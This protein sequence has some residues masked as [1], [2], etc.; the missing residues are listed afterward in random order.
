MSVIDIEN[1]EI[2]PCVLTGK[3]NY[4]EYSWG[5][6]HLNLVSPISVAKCKDTGMLYL[7]PRPNKK[8]REAMLAGTLPDAL[9]EYD[10]HIYNYAAV[11]K[12]R[13]ADFEERLL[14]LSRAFPGGGHSILDVG[15][16]S[17]NFM[18]VA[19]RHGWKAV[20]LEPFPNDVAR[21]REKGLDVMLG[22]AESLPYPDNTFDVVHAS[23]VF[24]HLENPLAAAKEAW[25]VLKPG[26]LLFIEVPNQL[27]NFG[28]HRDMFF[29]N[30][31]QRKR[32]IA[33]IHHLWFFGRRTLHALYDKA[34]FSDIRIVNKQ[35]KTFGGW[36][37]PFSFVSQTLSSIFYVTYIIRG[38]GSKPI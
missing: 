23:H 17:G 18:E 36:R 32:S 26:G 29:R 30:V 13:T 19:I 2:P 22:L 25:R 31:K 24:E 6:Y 10:E 8:N 5:K 11:D 38:I 9:K 27:D 14:D 20:G 7:C 28:F 12:L 35:H 37:L 16:S 33:S 4:E 34:L 15:T 3:I 21:C 1:F